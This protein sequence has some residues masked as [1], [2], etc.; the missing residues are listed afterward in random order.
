MGKFLFVTHFSSE[1][2]AT[3]EGGVV[4]PWLCS[5]SRGSETWSP[6]IAIFSLPS[7]DILVY[8]V[9]KLRALRKNYPALS[10]LGY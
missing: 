9:K 5:G 8:S 6:Y 7:K 2:T 3:Y 1:E 4:G 10:L